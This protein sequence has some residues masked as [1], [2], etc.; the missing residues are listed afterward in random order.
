MGC[1][2]GKI[3]QDAGA[4]ADVVIRASALARSRGVANASH[5][6]HTRALFD[7]GADVSIIQTGLAQQFGLKSHDVITIGH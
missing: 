3:D 2:E 4:I 7:T 1:V 5:E 6:I